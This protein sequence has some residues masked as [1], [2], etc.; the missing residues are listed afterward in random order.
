MT[1]SLY[2]SPIPVVKGNWRLEENW[3]EKEKEKEKGEGLDFGRAKMIAVLLT[4]L[5]DF[6]VIA[7]IGKTVIAC[8]VTGALGILGTLFFVARKADLKEL[9]KRMI[10]LE[11]RSAIHD[12]ELATINTKLGQILEL[13]RL[14]PTFLRKE[15]ND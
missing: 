2:P 3:K 5:E 1:G 12:I 15:K 6:S 13:S 8:A 14:I 4:L 10:E 9:E 7:E 11:K